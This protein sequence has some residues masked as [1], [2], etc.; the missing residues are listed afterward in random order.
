MSLFSFSRPR[1]KSND[2][3]ATADLDDRRAARRYD[4]NRPVT[5]V[6]DLCLSA[7][8]FIVNISL[9]GAAIRV[10]SGWYI[11][12]TVDWVTKLKSGD[13]IWLSDLL[14]EPVFCWVVAL[15][16]GVV[17]VRF[18]LTEAARSQLRQLIATS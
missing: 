13:D 2:N 17:R 6:R 14:P 1:T 3:G 5:I 4:K 8:S 10:Y 7:Q 15:D 9:T 16:D 12:E 11:P 18:S